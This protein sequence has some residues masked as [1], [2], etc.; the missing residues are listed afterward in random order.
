M[1]LKTAGVSRRFNM[2]T[3]TPQGDM[4]GHTASKG[5]AYRRIIAETPQITPPEELLNGKF[6]GEAI[7]RD[8]LKWAKS[9][10]VKVV[11]T[12][13]TVFN[14]H[15]IDQRYVK[16]ISSIYIEEG[17]LFLILPGLSQYD[18]SFFYDTNYHLS[19]RYQIAHSVQIGKA[20]DKMLFGGHAREAGKSNPQE[21]Y[22]ESEARPDCTI[23]GAFK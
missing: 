6:L 2:E 21:L 15:P 14:D 7:L 10:G 16:R 9:N 11:G 8:F 20:L 5:S 23:P 17:H 3:L 4:K 1:G 19:E 13:P 22:G 18:R 12:L